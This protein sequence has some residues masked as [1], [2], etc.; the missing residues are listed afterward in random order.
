MTPYFFATDWRKS[1]SSA[2]SKP[3]CTVLWSTYET[4][5][6][7]FTLATPMDSNCKYAIVPVASCVSVWS[8]LMPISASFAGSPSTRWAANI[9][10]ATFFA[11]LLM[12]HS[13]P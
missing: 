13:I 8:I 7:V 3:I 10:C 9:F 1:W 6:S 5:T 11:S 4:D 2:F 12:P